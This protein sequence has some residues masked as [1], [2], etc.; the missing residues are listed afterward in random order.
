MLRLLRNAKHY[1]W[2]RTANRGERHRLLVRNNWSPQTAYYVST[3]NPLVLITSQRAALG[4]I[5]AHGSDCQI[6]G[7]ALLSFFSLGTLLSLYSPLA[8]G[9][10]GT[11]GSLAAA[12]HDCHSY[13]S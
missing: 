3:K 1:G 6:T 12:K 10:C 2:T 5:L 4:T 11:N 7:G 8:L 13:E 9:S